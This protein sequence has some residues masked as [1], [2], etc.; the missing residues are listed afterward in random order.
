MSLLRNHVTYWKL[1]RL[2]SASGR[3]RRKNTIRSS[4]VPPG[5]PSGP[6]SARLN[7]STEARI[8]NPSH[9]KRGTD[10]KSVLP[11]SEEI[12]VPRAGGDGVDHRRQRDVRHRAGAA[13]TPQAGPVTPAGAGDWTG[14]SAADAHQPG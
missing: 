10:C 13:G 11:P 8:A 14:R 9:A 12:H 6:C 4:E 5:E 1:S 2:R 7:G 3:T